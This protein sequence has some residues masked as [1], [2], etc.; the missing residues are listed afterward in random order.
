MYRLLRHCNKRIDISHKWLTIQL[1]VAAVRFSSTSAATAEDKSSVEQLQHI[2][3]EDKK[4][5]GIVSTI[6]Y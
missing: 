6:G 3:D 2:F 4:N 1:N 5:G